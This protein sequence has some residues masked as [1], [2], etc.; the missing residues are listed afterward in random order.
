MR[1]LLLLLAFAAAGWAENFR[2]YLKDGGFHLVREYQV[3]EDRIR[4]YSVERSD[5]EEIPADLV[6]LKRTEAERK[7]RV[8]EEKKRAAMDDAEEK[9]ERAM[10]REIS[11]VPHEPGLYLARDG[12][13]TTLKMAEIRSTV[14][15]KQSILKILSPIPII[16]G[17]TA[18]ELD[19]A[20]SALDIP[21]VRPS[22]Y[23]RIGDM[24]RFGII[25]LAAAKNGRR[26]VG[27][28]IVEPATKQIFFE[29]RTVD[30]FRQQLQ[31]DLYKVWPTADLT[32]GEYAFVQFTEE[33]G[34]IQLWDFRVPPGA[35]Q[36]P[37]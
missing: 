21:D 6:D 25:R 28:M 8:D 32:P 27:T 37:E 29:L 14:N 9:F 11:S 13:A 26:D 17:K 1:A 22:F 5:W 18:L 34:Y 20:N 15:K 30:V 23:F 16:P 36:R 10:A 33:Q 3:A 2:L 4:Y 19:G 7:S 24:N 35:V 12:K 31:G